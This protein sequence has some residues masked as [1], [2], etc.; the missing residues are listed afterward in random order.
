MEHEN[1][2]SICQGCTEYSDFCICGA[3]TAD[4]ISAHTA[5]TILTT[6]TANS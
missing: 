4:W 2:R 1:D 6:A 5:L 3:D